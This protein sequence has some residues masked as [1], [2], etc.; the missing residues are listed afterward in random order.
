MDRA[1]PVQLDEDKIMI[2][3]LEYESPYLSVHD[4]VFS[5]TRAAD[6]RKRMPTRS[7]ASAP[8]GSSNR[9]S[10]PGFGSSK[11]VMAEASR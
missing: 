4:V 1:I 8:K 11:R 2:T 7:C 9:W 10:R 3:F 5:S 6:P